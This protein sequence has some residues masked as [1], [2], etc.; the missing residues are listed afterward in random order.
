M[1]KGNPYHKG[2]GVGGGQFTYGPEGKAFEA[3]MAGKPN[4]DPKQKKAYDQGKQVWANHE[5]LQA[6]AQTNTS[7]GDGVEGDVD[8]AQV[9]KVM[10]SFNRS[11]GNLADNL[12]EMDVQDLQQRYGGN[13]ATMAEVHKQIGVAS[14]GPPGDRIRRQVLSDLGLAGTPVSKKK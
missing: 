9:S 6:D 11:K 12:R 3:G 10:K 1:G 8:R 7:H 14:Y 13:A 5:R 2:A 4:T